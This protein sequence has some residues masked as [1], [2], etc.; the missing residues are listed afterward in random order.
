ME[1]EE[2]KKQ[3]LFPCLADH[4]GLRHRFSVFHSPFYI[5][6][7]FPSCLCGQNSYFAGTSA[8]LEKSGVLCYKNASPVIEYAGRKHP[9]QASPYSV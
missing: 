9:R 1:N 7:F 2:W 3:K 5:L 4:V 8:A 6:H